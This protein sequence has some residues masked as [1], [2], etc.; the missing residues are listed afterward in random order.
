MFTVRCYDLPWASFSNMLG[1]VVLNSTDV[2]GTFTCSV[3]LSVHYCLA[4]WQIALA[5][6]FVDPYSPKPS[7]TAT[8][9]SSPVSPSSS[10]ITSPSLVDVCVGTL[11]SPAFSCVDNT[12]VA[13]GDVLVDSGIGFS[14]ALSFH[15]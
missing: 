2:L 9:V 3:K 15:A 5:V 8:P 4:A 1:V 12:W 13:T 6:N 10:P 11:P 7:P 14:H